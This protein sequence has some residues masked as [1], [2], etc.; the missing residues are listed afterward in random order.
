MNTF[1]HAGS[2]Y[3]GIVVGYLIN[4]YKDIK[5]SKVIRNALLILFDIV[6]CFYLML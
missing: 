3:V 2:Y 4:K 5:M 6:H 1:T